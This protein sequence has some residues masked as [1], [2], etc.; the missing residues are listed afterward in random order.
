MDNILH[1]IQD[2]YIDIPQDQI[3]EILQQTW[4]EALT[5]A[6]EIIKQRMLHTILDK[7]L[8]IC[9]ILFHNIED[10]PKADNHPVQSAPYDMP[11]K[12]DEEQIQN[13]IE[14]IRRKITENDQLLNQIKTSPPEPTETDSTVSGQSPVD[15]SEGEGYYVYGVVRNDHSSTELPQ[16]GID[17]TYPVSKFPYQAIQAIVSQVSLREFGEEVLKANL[18]DPG[19]LESKVRAHQAVLETVCAGGVTIPMRFCTI[20]LSE[21]HFQEMLACHYDDF[22][23]ALNNLVGKQERGVKAYCDQVLLA[24]YFQ[25]TDESVKILKAEIEGKATGTAYFAKRKLEQVIAEKVERINLSLAQVSH[26]RLAACAESACILPTQSKEV[27]G[28]D[29]EMYLNGAYL[30]AEEKLA[31]FRAELEELENENGHFGFFYELTGPWPPYNFVTI[32]KEEVVSE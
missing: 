19:W 32:G 5:E 17:P 6:K 29:D 9:P 24:Q 21:A 12:K 14:T 30:V 22:V 18:N 27:T 15:E 2:E 8:S 7:T 23:E 31:A 1:K 4:E 16:E 3:T 11:I 20:Y 10:E 26:D 25:E 28:R 13:K